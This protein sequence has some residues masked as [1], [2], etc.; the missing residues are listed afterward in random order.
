MG[1]QMKCVKCRVEAVNV[2]YNGYKKYE[3]CG[4]CGFEYLGVAG[5]KEMKKMGGLLGGLKM[6]SLW[7]V[8]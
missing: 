2:Q 4:N 1:N 6:V 8:V 7:N 5:P 3:V